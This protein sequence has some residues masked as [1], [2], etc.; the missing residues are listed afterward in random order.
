MA[1]ETER[2]YTRIPSMKMSADEVTALHRKVMALSVLHHL[3][4]HYPALSKIRACALTEYS[5][6]RPLQDIIDASEK[7]QLLKDVRS[8]LHVRFMTCE[9][10]G[11]QFFKVD[12]GLCVLVY[13]SD[14][15]GERSASN[16]VGW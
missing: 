6:H 5:V 12:V 8:H 1:P 4:E 9:A 11:A 15:V 10:N 16:T 13:N 7:A 3:V 2:Y 14:S